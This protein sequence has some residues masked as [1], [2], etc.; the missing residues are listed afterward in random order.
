MILDAMKRHKEIGD[1]QQFGCGALMNLAKNDTDIRKTIAKEGGIK[2]I[3]NAMKEHAKDV[4]VQEK[5]CGALRN[6]ACNADNKITIAKEGG[7]GM[8]RNAMKR[9]PNLQQ[10]GSRALKNLGVNYN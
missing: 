7:I 10:F 2:V 5:G 3:L 8:I 4:K 9:H 6:L 1:V